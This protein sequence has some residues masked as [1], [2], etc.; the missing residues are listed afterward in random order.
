MTVARS[1]LVDPHVTPWYHCISN[2]VR[3]AFLLHSVSDHRKRWIQTRLEELAAIFSIEVAGYAVLDTHLHLL[4][5]IHL[6]RAKRWSK[7]EVLQRWARLFPPRGPDRKPLRSIDKWIKSKISDHKFVNTARKRLVDLG[8]FM[9]SL[10][11]PLARQANQED[12]THGAFWAAR[13]KSIAILDEEALLATCA[14]IDLNPFAAGCAKLPELARYTSLVA[15][16]DWCRRQGRWSD[17]QAARAGS[18]LGAQAARGMEAGLWLCPL[19]DRR[20]RGEERVGLLEDFSLGSYLL[21]IDATSRMLRPGK[22]RVGPEVAAILE[23]LGTSPETWQ[24]TLQQMFVRPRLKGVAFAFR[25]QR[26]RDA[27]QARGCHHLHNLNGCRA[28]GP[29]RAA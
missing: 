18:A 28:R 19:D 22:A 14:Y 12:G 8:W 4:V 24:V 27:A 15:R 16:L 9:K 7:R 13:Y 6:R 23:R 20:G 11:E 5:H 2:T 1:Q 29:D 3:G 10:K 21:L 26:L 17:L 25:R